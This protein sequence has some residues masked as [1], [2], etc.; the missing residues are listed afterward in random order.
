[1][2]IKRVLPSLLIVA[3]LAVASGYALGRPNFSGADQFLIK[4]QPTPQDAIAVV[5]LLCWIILGIVGLAILVMALRAGATDAQRSFHSWS[6][7]VM[8]LLAGAI[9]LSMGTVRHVD[10]NYPM[11]CGSGPTYSAEV[12]K[13][14]SGS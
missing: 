4:G 13:L 6:R 10:S 8:T 7:A 14:V 1:M 9:I 3:V 2:A 12:D 5:S 11:C